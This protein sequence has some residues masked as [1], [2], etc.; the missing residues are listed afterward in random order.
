MENNI[1][2]KFFKKRGTQLGIS[3][4]NGY[5]IRGFVLVGFSDMTAF[6][7]ILAVPI[8]ILLATVVGGFVGSVIHSILRRLIYGKQ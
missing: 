6:E 3:F 4:A 1:K 7:T 5:I 2:Q 8:M